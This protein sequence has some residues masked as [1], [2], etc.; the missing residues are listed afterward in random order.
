MRRMTNHGLLLFWAAL[1]RAIPF[2]GIVQMANIERIIK[3]L[4]LKIIV[5][6]WVLYTSR[7][8]WYN[9]SDAT[10]R[11]GNSRISP[12]AENIGLVLGSR[13]SGRRL[14]LHFRSSW[15]YSFRHFSS[16]FRFCPLS[17]CRQTAEIN[18]GWD[19]FKKHSRKQ[20]DFSFCSHTKLCSIDR[21]SLAVAN[22]HHGQTS[23]AA[24]THS[25]RWNWPGECPRNTFTKTFRG[26]LWR[27]DIGETFRRFR[28][29]IFIFPPF[30][31]VWISALVVQ[32]IGHSPAK[33]EM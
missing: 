8:G 20:N 6:I 23:H 18:H 2:H 28:T 4:L 24:H 26:S 13:H 31:V 27:T 21:C 30:G 25:S 12:H 10:F 29:L 33:G 15:K 7:C 14:R 1:Y 9:Y 5:C 22:S 16:P 32:W 11:L 19:R 3:S 17:L